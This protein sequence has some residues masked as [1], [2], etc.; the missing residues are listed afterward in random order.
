MSRFGKEAEELARWPQSERATALKRIVPRRVVKQ[1]LRE[2]GL[3]GA[4]PRLPGWLVIWVVIGL[5]L[6]CRDSC[7]QIYRWLCPWTRR[8]GVPGRSTLCEARRRIGVAP[9]LKLARRTVVPLATP[10]TPGAFYCG[11]RLI[12]LDGFVLNVPDSPANARVFGRPGGPRPGAFPQVRVLSLCEAGTH[13]LLDW[14]AKPQRISE[15]AMAPTLL[16]RL[17]PGCLLLWD[18][19]FR[20]YDLVRRVVERGAC[21]LGRGR[22]DVELTPLRRL[23]DG[24]YLARLYPTAGDRRRDR[25]GLTVRVIDYALDDPGRGRH[26]GKPQRLITTL[27]DEKAHPARRLVEL[28]HVRWEQEL[29]IDEVKTHEMQRPVMRSQTPAGVIQELCGLMLSHYVLRGLM[30]E[31]AARASAAGAAPVSPTQLSFTA[32]LKILQCRLPS[33]PATPA[34]QHRWWRDLLAEI[35]AERLEPRRNRINP[36]VVRQQRSKWPRKGS[37]HQHWPQPLHEFRDCIVIRC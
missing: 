36:R 14:V 30:A 20:S 1:V 5:G 8:R 31:A 17:P 33:W 34:A 2:C 28:Y 6:F 7:R 9:L 21:L 32:T 25:N 15:V 19:N 12:G 22:A 11:M 26:H 24:S 29:A 3:D 23:G 13:A 10:D 35:A 27:L 16:G 37:K 4:C 18:Q